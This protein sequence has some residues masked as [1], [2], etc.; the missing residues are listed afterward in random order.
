MFQM[1]E[2]TVARILNQLLGKYVQDLDTENL[3]V[4]IF[5]GT[6]QLSDLKLKP[7]ALVSNLKNFTKIA[8]PVFNFQY[9][10]NLPIEVK[11]GTI[12]KIWLQIP[13]TALWNQPIVVN[14][15]NIHMVVNPV[16]RNEPYD[17]ENNKR[18]L[19]AFKKRTLELL[20]NEGGI[21][22]GKSNID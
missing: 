1:L 4:G 14:I 17:A 2:G 5:S 3:N 13:W 15:D 22:G 12:G 16:V 19:R 7:E 18:L 8:L 6:V 21:L 11:A 9:E 10:L 20:E